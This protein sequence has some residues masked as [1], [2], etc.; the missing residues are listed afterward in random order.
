[1]QLAREL[2]DQDIEKDFIVAE[3]LHHNFYEVQ[4][5]PV[6]IQ[7]VVPSVQHLVS[8]LFTL[9]PPE[10]NTQAIPS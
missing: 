1:M 5:E 8:K 7:I 4:Q 9:L 6:D 3:S 10:A 2:N